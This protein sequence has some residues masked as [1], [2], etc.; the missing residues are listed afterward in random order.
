MLRA[1]RIGVGAFREG[2]DGECE[3]LGE[4]FAKIEGGAFVG[5]FV[6]IIGGQLDFFVWP[7][8]FSGRDKAQ[9]DELVDADGEVLGGNAAGL[10]DIGPQPASN[11]DA[12]AI[13]R[14]LNLGTHGGNRGN[15][16]ARGEAAACRFIRLD[17]QRHI[18]D[19][20]QIDHVAVFGR[21]GAHR[22]ISPASTR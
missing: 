5:D 4:S 22:P 18:V 11:R 12:L 8:F 20:P 9:V 1:E 13:A 17:Y 21:G 14:E 7:D 10:D 15:R 3:G 19:L 2:I 6:A 16:K